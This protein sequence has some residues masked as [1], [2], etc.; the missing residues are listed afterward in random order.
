MSSIVLGFLVGV[1]GALSPGPLAVALVARSGEPRRGMLTHLI[2]CVALGLGMGPLLRVA[3]ET[4]SGKIALALVYVAFGIV[5]TV[6]HLSKGAPRKLG[7]IELVAKWI[8][9]VGFAAW[10]GL[11]GHDLASGLGF[12]GG[13]WAGVAAWFGLLSTLAAKIGARRMDACLRACTAVVAGVLIAVGIY[14]ARE[15][16]QTSQ[17]LV[18]DSGMEPT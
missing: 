1:F 13:V 18:T 9:V 8:L 11:V 4:P 3:A 16:S 14:A 2:V 15:F 10:T 12:A 5:L 7:G 6:R 17:R